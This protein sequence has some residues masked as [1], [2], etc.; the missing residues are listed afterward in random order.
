MWA[1]LRRDRLRRSAEGEGR[2]IIR[3]L[4]LD[5]L[6]WTNLLSNNSLV[7]KSLEMLILVMISVGTF[8]ESN[9]KPPYTYTNYSVSHELCLKRCTLLN[10][11]HSDVSVSYTSIVKVSPTVFV[12][13]PMI[14]NMLKMNKLECWYRPMGSSLS[15]L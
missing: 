1:Q 15:A 3:Y 13:P 8:G 10:F 11:D 9:S 7:L 5:W 12:R 2:I 6:L 4:L 14:A